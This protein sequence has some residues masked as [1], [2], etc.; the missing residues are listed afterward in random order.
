MI[1]GELIRFRH[2]AD[3]SQGE[4]ARAMGLS[5]RGYQDIEGRDDEDELSA[6]H[7]LA[8]ERC[9]LRLAVQ[10]GS[11]DLA[12]PSIRRDAQDF[13]DLFRGARAA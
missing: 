8:I 7:V 10:R 1:V 13:M 9:S 12:L 6:R 2:R 11:I 3:L 5:L 4:M